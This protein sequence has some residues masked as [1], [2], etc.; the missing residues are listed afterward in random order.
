MTLHDFDPNSPTFFDDTKAATRAEFCELLDSDRLSVFAFAT[1][2]LKG[3]PIQFATLDFGG[4]AHMWTIKTAEP[5]DPGSQA[6]HGLSQADVDAGYPMAAMLPI[7]N[8]YLGEG[9]KVITFSPDFMREALVRACRLEGL[10]CFGTSHW[11]NGQEMLAHLVGSYNWTSN[12]WSRPKL[13]D[14]IRDLPMPEYFAPIGTAL[15]NAERLHALIEHFGIEP[16][17]QAA[18]DTFERCG[19][20][21][22]CGLELPGGD[23]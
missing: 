6:F 9:R 19:E 16:Q 1:S 12:R 23:W 11:L 22:I 5:L 17:Q 14:C 18:S 20:Y 21:C 8:E 7:L 3:V 13:T 10:E 15:G 2:S 4:D